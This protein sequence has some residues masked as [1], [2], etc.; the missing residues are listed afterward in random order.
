M[1][2]TQPSTVSLQMNSQNTCIECWFLP[3]GGGGGGGKLPILI[4]AFI[5]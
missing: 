2:I 4:Y 5:N 1:K 3:G